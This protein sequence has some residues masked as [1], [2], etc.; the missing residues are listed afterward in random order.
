MQEKLRT[1]SGGRSVNVEDVRRVFIVGSGTMGGEIGLQS[2]IFGYNVTLFDISPGILENAVDQMKTHLA[3]FMAGGRLTKA[4]ADGILARMSTTTVPKQAAQADLLI[5]AV[6]EDPKLK[7]RVLAQ[8]G[9]ICPPRTIFATNT[10]MLLPSMLAKSTGRPAQFAALHFHAH[11]WVSNVVDVMPHRNTSEE[12][13]S[14][15]REFAIRI[16]QIPICLKKESRGYVFNAI[17]S[18]MNREALSLVVNGIASTEDI[19]RS[20]MAITK[21]PVGPFGMLDM[22]GLDTVWDISDYWARRA[23]FIPQ[24]RK[25]ADFIKKYVDQGH[26]GVKS[27]Q[28]FYT[29]PSPAYQQPDFLHVK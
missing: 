11:V 29:Y 13:I 25:N 10:S 15:L 14:V 1:R 8:F 26:R 7:R 19:D 17:Y 12:T 9:E 6:P 21:M 3:Q 23:F 4:D 20:W 16:G 27:G 24:L 5:E 18:A 2:A 28:G 22:V